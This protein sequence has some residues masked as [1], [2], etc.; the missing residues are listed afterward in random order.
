M[1]YEMFR[2]LFIIA[3]SL[4]AVMLVVSFFLFMKFNIPKVVGEMSGATARKAIS[5]IRNQNE[6]TGD[7]AYKPSPVNTERGKLTDKI[8]QSG[9]IKQNILST[10]V[11]V[12][13]E[14]I[15]TQE[16]DCASETTM[17]SQSM[18]DNN[19]IG[20]TQLTSNETQLI[21]QTQVTNEIQLINQ[22]QVTNE[23][24]VLDQSQVIENYKF[25]V[26]FDITFIH[27]KEEIN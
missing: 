19:T 3:G 13:T 16:L 20:E 4:S 15:G 24:T 27:T 9:K 17:I 25:E 12:G 11:N 26:E 1:T 7:K 2:Y 10:G 6:L 8:S 22:T 5:S 23:T 14:K 18:N 21:Y